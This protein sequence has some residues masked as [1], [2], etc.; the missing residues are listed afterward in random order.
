MAQK[1]NVSI[2]FVLDEMC[3]AANIPVCRVLQ[4]NLMEFIYLNVIFGNS[5]MLDVVTYIEIIM[6]R[7]LLHYIQAHL[8]LCRLRLNCLKAYVAH[9]VYFPSK[10]INYIQV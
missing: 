4:L 10:H 3:D 9:F 2:A 1:P 7:M 8:I 5:V 6:L